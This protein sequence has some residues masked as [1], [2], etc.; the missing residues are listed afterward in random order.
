MRIPNPAFVLR[1]P[2]YQ[3][4]R[5]LV[6]YC[7]FQGR[8]HGS[9][10]SLTPWNASKSFGHILFVSSELRPFLFSAITCS[11]RI[12]CNFTVSNSGSCF[13]LSQHVLYCWT[14]RC[15]SG[16]IIIRT[17]ITIRTTW[18]IFAPDQ[19]HWLS[20]TVQVFHHN[21]W[22]EHLPLGAVSS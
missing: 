11:N 20:D 7:F 21:L 14:L 1:R 2:A 6:S 5:L 3:N 22:V 4:S 19:T 17:T 8:H 9:C 13:M 18:S 16:I 15:N 12:I 10:I